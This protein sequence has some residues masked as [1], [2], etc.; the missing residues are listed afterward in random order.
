MR[1]TD[2]SG[3]ADATPATHAWTIASSCAS[4]TTQT[5]GANADSWIDQA[6]PSQNS[7]TDSTLK[8]RSKSGSQNARALVRFPLPAI[9]AGCVVQAATLRLFSDSAVSGRTLQALRLT[10][11]W[12]ENGV[13]WANQPATNGTSATTSSG[14][15]WRQ[16]NVLAHVQAMYSGANNGF[17]VRDA[18]ENAGA[19]PSSRSTAARRAPTCRSSCVTFGPPDT[20][21]PQTT[22]DSGPAA[23]TTSTSASFAF[24]SSETGSSFE[25]SLDGAAFTSCTSPAA[26]TGLGVGPH[27]F[28]VRA[29]DAGG[30]VDPTPA[31]HSWTIEAPPPDTTPPDTTL[32][33]QPSNPTAST[34][35]S[36]TLSSSE[37]GSTFQCSLDGAAVHGL[38]LPGRVLGPRPRRAHVRR[39]RDR[40]RRERRPDAGQPTPGRSARAARQ[41]PLTATAD[42]WI[43][44]SS[45]S[46]NK[47]TDASLKVRSK[48]GSQNVRSLVRFDLPA[49]PAGCVVQGATLRLFSDAAVNGRTL[50]ALRVNASWTENGVTWAN[51]PSTTGSAATTS[52]GTGWRQWNVL[53]QL[54]AMYSGTNNGFLIRDA[55]EGAGAGPEQSFHSREKGSEAPQLVITFVAG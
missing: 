33:G 1:A 55:T 43:D 24:S 3:N 38:H 27:T 7:G 25:C 26:Y 47:G 50:Q 30:N 16:W 36:F 48:N 51:Q 21:P 15:G 9:P 41:S 18:T 5:V 52:S 6:S 12:S 22:I 45:S 2:A 13:T 8:V 31:S 32:A 23:T 19:S 14:T 29:I 17:L 37:S 54:Q 11:T 28:A 42:S 4:V 49:I 20:T 35:A 40:R 34:S 53:S 44:Q 39:A 46:Q 10:G